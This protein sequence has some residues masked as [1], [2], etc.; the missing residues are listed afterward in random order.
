MGKR[1]IGCSIVAVLVIFGFICCSSAEDVAP[2]DKTPDWVNAG[3]PIKASDIP[4]KEY[5]Y[6][7]NWVDENG[8][9]PQQYVVDLFARHQVVI[10]GED[11]GMREHKEFISELI[12]KLYHE[13]GVRCIGWEFSRHTHNDRLEKIVTA[14]EYHKEEALDFAR[15][16]LGHAWNKKELWDII[17]AVWR[18]NKNLEPGQERMRLLGLHM[19]FDFTQFFITL[20]T[21]P[22]D[23]PEV[24]EIVAEFALKYDRSMMEQVEKEIIGKGQ[25]GLLYVGRC[26]DFTHYEYPPDLWWGR[27]IMGNLLYKKYGERVFQIWLSSGFLAPID[28]VMKLRGHEPTGFDLYRSPFANILSPAGWDAPEV[29]LSD[30]ARGYVYLKPGSRLR[31]WTP[32]K[33]FVTDEIFKKYR[34]YYEIDFGR[35]FKN[36]AEV[37]KYLQDRLK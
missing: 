16:Q 18:L 15:D 30:I 32:I 9:G 36:A 33:G 37:D 20:K 31:M 19:D 35:T 24:K 6:L 34:R 26:H 29:P 23:S 13:A 22:E 14:Q 11:H 25:K 3:K 27:P 21:K 7:A 28:D 1:V 10:I 17:E 5:G 8:K 4:G 2:R 12:P